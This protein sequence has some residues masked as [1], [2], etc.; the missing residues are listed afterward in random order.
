MT[1]PYEVA[2]QIRFKKA[3]Y[4]RFL[5]TKQWASF[6]KLALPDARFVFH[7]VNGEVLH[8]FPSTRALVRPTARMLGDARTS[9]RVCNPELAPISDSEVSAIWAMEDYLVFPPNRAK[10]GMVI[11][12]FGHYHEVWERQGDDWLLKRLDL[13]R[14][15]LDTSTFGSS[16]QKADAFA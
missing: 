11:R 14:Q 5:D 10:P 9:H 16:E 4:C 1:I 12:G 15:I 6:E 2:E 13:R 3:Q 7:G 8:D